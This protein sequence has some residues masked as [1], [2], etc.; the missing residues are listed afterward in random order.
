MDDNLDQTAETPRVAYEPV[1]DSAPSARVVAPGAVPSGSRYRWAIA[2]GVVALVVVGTVF[3]ISLFTGRAANAVV[4]GYVPSD[5]IMY[6]EARL[7][8]PGDQRN[9]VGQFLS[10]FPGFA[11]QAAIE[12]KVDEVLDRL[13]A[14][15]TNG[16]QAYSSD[17]KPWFS[18]ELGFSVGALPDPAVLSSAAPMLDKVSFLF[19]ASI[20]DEAAARAWFDALFADGTATS[21]ESYGGVTLTMFGGGQG[22]FALLDGK[23][24][25]FGDVASVKAAADTKGAGGFAAKPELQ[26]ALDATSG[27]HV[28]FVY[29]ALRPFYDW[30][31]KAGGSDVQ[32]GEALLDLIP[33]WGAFSLRVEGD[34]LVMDALARTTAGTVTGESRASALADHLPV[35]VLAL[36]IAN[37]SGK[38]LLK[39]LD[40]YRSQPSMQSTIEA[41]DQAIGVLGGPDAA[42]GWIGDLG[43]SLNRTDGGLEGGVVIVP[44]DRAAA[45]RLFTS[46]RT[47]AS[48]ADPSVEISLR[49]EPY[50]GT[51]ITIVDF[52]SV[53]DL[54]GQVGVSPEMLGGISPSSSAHV[55]LAYAFTDQVIVLGADPGF[56]RHVL[57]TTA[58]TSIAANDRYKTLAGRAGQGSGLTF[59]DL[60]AI[61][62]LVESKMATANPAVQAE[63]EQNV[64]PFLVPFDALV[65]SNS[66]KGDV[67]RSTLVVTVK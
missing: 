16:D 21:T 28:G 5:S 8:L 48:L 27:D 12:T 39:T 17:I 35:G 57:D 2:L 30:S 19:L 34:A 25:V 32:G 29:V 7:D 26:A 59:V 52:G 44:T 3:A 38:S 20:K 43:I 15:A 24:A 55:E 65:A 23:V 1:V 13:V 66:I 22:A 64:K 50:A 51:T 41:I 37:D 33:D 46:L 56:V 60:T 18:G 4:L 54:A 36:S 14:G 31:L 10:K 63:Y 62:E 6:V 9:A 61:R 45:E 11:D 53:A 58:A 40:L 67:S 49:D 42:I 47:F